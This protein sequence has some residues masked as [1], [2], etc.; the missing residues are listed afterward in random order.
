VA[1]IGEVEDARH[2]AAYRPRQREHIGQ[3]HPILP[4]VLVHHR[5]MHY[6]P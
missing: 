2:Q 3:V 6:L 4:R 5:H 1:E